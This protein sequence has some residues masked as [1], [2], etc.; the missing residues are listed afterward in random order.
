[1]SLLSSFQRLINTRPSRLATGETSTLG[2]IRTATKRAG[3]S[4]KN[5]GSS[6]GRRLGI[7]KF[8]DQEVVPGNIIVR[9]RGT[10]F[11]PGPHVGMG[12]DHTIFALVPG[13][14]R[15][16]KTK[17][18]QGERKFVGLVLERGEKLPR[19]KASLGRSRYFGNEIVKVTS[20]PAQPVA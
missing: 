1:M 16:Y 8:S 9:Q 5:G 15:F 13:Y 3:G 20:P 19:D 6:A 12:R 7:K 2:Q 17:W 4:T 11:H 14:V 18:G 10:Q